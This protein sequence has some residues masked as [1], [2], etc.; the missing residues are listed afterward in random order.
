MTPSYEFKDFNFNESNVILRDLQ[1][2]AKM[3]YKFDF[4]INR[5]GVNSLSLNSSLST[6]FSANSVPYDLKWYD[7]YTNRIYRGVV[8]IPFYE[9][10]GLWGYENLSNSLVFVSNLSLYRSILSEFSSA[11]ITIN[12]SENDSVIYQIIPRTY[13]FDYS[14]TT[15]R[16]LSSF[17]QL[18]KLTFAS[19]WYISIYKLNWFVFRRDEK[20]SANDISINFS[21]S[22][23]EDFNSLVLKNQYSISSLF[24]GLIMPKES[25]SISYNISYS[26]QDT[27]KGIPSFY[28]NFGI[29]VGL[30]TFSSK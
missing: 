5:F 27:L 15:T 1:M 21:Y 11:G 8:A 28:S 29:G 16:E 4:N 7:F 10:L 14:T 18:N 25:Y 17:R 12:L 3:T 2:N 19:V 6:T 13:S 9:Y 20:A 22:R 30:S 23:E 24:S 26:Y